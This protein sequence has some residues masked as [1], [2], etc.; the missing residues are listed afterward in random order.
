MP[1]AAMASSAARR[2]PSKRLMTKIDPSSAEPLMI[3]GHA[4]LQYRA[5][6]SL[7]CRAAGKSIRCRQAKAQEKIASDA[8]Q[9][10]SAAAP[11]AA[12]CSHMGRRASETVSDSSRTSVP[13]VM[14]IVRRA[15][16]SSAKALA[17]TTR[18]GALRMNR[19]TALHASIC[20][21]EPRPNQLPNTM[22]PSGVKTTASA[23]VIG[24]ERTR[25]AN[26]INLRESAR[27]FRND[28]HRSVVTSDAAVIA[29]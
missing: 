10:T 26:V 3:N 13:M 12:P 6:V 2:R 17:R 28:R 22:L 16:I 1:K 5:K 23:I 25:V 4:K 8:I 21:C 15:I 29:K 7:D 18:N 14:M 20:A 11:I 19:P 24:S 27:D 9:I